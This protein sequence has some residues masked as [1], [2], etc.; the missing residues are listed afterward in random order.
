MRN[1][2]AAFL[3]PVRGLVRLAWLFFRLLAMMATSVSVFLAGFVTPPETD[4][5]ALACPATGELER[6][7]PQLQRSFNLPLAGPSSL[8]LCR[9]IP[10]QTVEEPL[11]RLQARAESAADADG[12]KLDTRNASSGPPVDRAHVWTLTLPATRQALPFCRFC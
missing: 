11:K 4:L 2:A 6:S 5:P 3:P 10:G 7:R 8:R 12:F 1:Q 9:I